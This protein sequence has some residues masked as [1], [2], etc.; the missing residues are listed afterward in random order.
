MRKKSI[1]FELYPS[2]S[3]NIRERRKQLGLTQKE[4]GKL[5]NVSFRTIQNYENGITP[6]SPYI[7]REN[8]FSFRSF[9][10]NTY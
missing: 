2:L 8:S 7:Y 5:A 3:F 10:R 4:L 9:C 6:P 1:V